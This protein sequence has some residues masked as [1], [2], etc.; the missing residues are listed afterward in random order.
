MYLVKVSGVSGLASLSPV[1][2]SR[3]QVVNLKVIS[4][5]DIVVVVLVGASLGLGLLFVGRPWLLSALLSP[6]SLWALI[7]KTVREEFSG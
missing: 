5:L 1:A 2:L 3:D 7:Q 4:S 6:A